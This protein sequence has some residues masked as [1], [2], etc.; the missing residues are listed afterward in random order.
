MRGPWGRLACIRGTFFN[1]DKGIFL[2]CTGLV[3][4]FC[5]NFSETSVGFRG[6]VVDEES[7]VILGSSLTVVREQGRDSTKC[8][9][10]DQ[11]RQSNAR[12]QRNPEPITMMQSFVSLYS[13]ELV[14]SLLSPSLSPVVSGLAEI[15]TH[16]T[17]SKQSNSIPKNSSDFLQSPSFPCTD[18]SEHT[19]LAA[20]AGGLRRLLAGPPQLPLLCRLD[21]RSDQISNRSSRKIPVP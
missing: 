5:Q 19:F 7:M 12:K 4:L 10:M 3:L 14:L 18:A 15:H 2:F 6:P 11:D 13:P 20:P 21:R 9:S 16:I 17:L 1:I 8:T